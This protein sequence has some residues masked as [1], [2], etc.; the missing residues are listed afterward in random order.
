MFEETENMP[1]GSRLVRHCWCSTTPTICPVHVL[2]HYL[3]GL[4][5]GAKP[6][7]DA[8]PLKGLSQLRCLLELMN[9]PDA[10]HYDTKSFRRGHTQDLIDAGK[11]AAEIYLAGGWR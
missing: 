6:F 5:I 11:P 10:K 8:A 2:G 1:L 9:V 3:S 4:T 7:A